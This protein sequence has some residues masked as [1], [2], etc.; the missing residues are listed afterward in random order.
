MGEKIGYTSKDNGWATFE[1][2]RIPRTNM[3]M[4]IANVTKDGAFELKGDPRVMYTIMMTIRLKIVM[5]CPVFLQFGV[6]M[7]SRYNTVRRQFKT[8]HGNKLER[9]IIDYQT[10][11]HVLV[12]II[13]FVYQSNQVSHFMQDLFVDM[14]NGI[15]N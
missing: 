12:P 6:Q 10:Q 8:Y 14:Q 3:L 1:Q 4:G 13:A 5:S 15:K 7:A 11:Q 9:K 2:V